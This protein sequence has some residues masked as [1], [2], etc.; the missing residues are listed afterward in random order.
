M[1]SSEHQDLKEIIPWS[2]RSSAFTPVCLPF[3]LAMVLAPPT[4]KHTLFWQIVNQTYNAGFN[5]GNRNGSSETTNE[6]LLAAYFKA[7]ATA[8]TIACGLRALS[9]MLLGTNTGA[10]ANIVNYFIGYCAVATSSGVNV[11]AMRER[12]LE[13]GIS[14]RDAQ[15]GEE[16]GQS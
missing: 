13:T 3:F 15:T 2:M 7:T 9:P 12:E 8:V 16:L 11:L 4:Q 10:V 14:V 6:Q 5:Y 1:A